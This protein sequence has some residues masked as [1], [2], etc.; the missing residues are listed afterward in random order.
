MIKRS[1]K[2]SHER[3]VLGFD[4]VQRFYSIL[5]LTHCIILHMKLKYVLTKVRYHNIYLSCFNRYVYL[6]IL[7]YLWGTVCALGHLKTNCWRSLVLL[8]AGRRSN[9]QVQHLTLS[10]LAME[11][12]RAIKIP[13]VPLNFII[14]SEVVQMVGFKKYFLKGLWQLQGDFY[15]FVQHSLFC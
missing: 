13:C 4:Q 11:A 1:S 9:M 8:W 7:R 5:F 12:Y 6:G 14:Y 3:S 10:W 15:P 2:K